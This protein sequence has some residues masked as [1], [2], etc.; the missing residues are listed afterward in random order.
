MGK[1]DQQPGS[2]KTHK[3]LGFLGLSKAESPM[4][5]KNTQKPLISG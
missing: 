3:T 2:M 4:A 1:Q 5:I